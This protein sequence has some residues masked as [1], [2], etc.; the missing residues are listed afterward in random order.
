MHIYFKVLPKKI[1]MHHKLKLDAK[2]LETRNYIK[3]ETAKNWNET[4]TLQTYNLL[5]LLN[6]SNKYFKKYQ[7]IKS[8]QT[9]CEDF[10]QDR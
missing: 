2:V 10:T 7:W 9:G 4:I 1:S 8:I 5:L 6:R 3:L